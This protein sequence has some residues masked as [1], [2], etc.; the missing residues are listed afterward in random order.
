ME[1]RNERLELL[2]TLLYHLELLI[3]FI[4]L[5]S[6]GQELLVQGTDV[7]A[8]SLHVRVVIELCADYLVAFVIVLLEFNGEVQ[9]LLLD[10]LKLLLKL[11]LLVVQFNLAINAVEH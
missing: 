3:E 9:N 4:D 6:L 10:I 7:R 11:L 8:Y 1:Q 2:H 5:V